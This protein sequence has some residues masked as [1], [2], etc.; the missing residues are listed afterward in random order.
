M[1]IFCRLSE[2]N[3][4]F[5][6]LLVNFLLFFRSSNWIEQ[7]LLLNS[8][9]IVQF[10]ACI[11]LNCFFPYSTFW[12]NILMGVS[13]VRDWWKFK[14][15]SLKNFGIFGVLLSFFF[16][17]SQFFLCFFLQSLMTKFTKIPSSIARK[18]QK[19]KKPLFPIKSTKYVEHFSKHFINFFQM[20]FYKQ[21]LFHFFIICAFFCVTFL[22][23]LK[24]EISKTKIKMFRLWRHRHKHFS[25]CSKNRN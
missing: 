21:F 22:F 19:Y 25:I 13:G 7:V 3:L 5:V 12:L 8:K 15:A 10:V 23:Q 11:I 18:I 20:H 6:I 9:T 4:I 16:L 24:K 2:L 14:I 17:F 1:T